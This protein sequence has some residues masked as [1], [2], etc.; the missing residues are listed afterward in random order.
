MLSV[1]RHPPVSQRGVALFV[2]LV[3]VLLSMLL[4]LWA[5]RTALFNEMVVGNDADYQ[6]AYEAAQALLQDAET[7]IQRT[8]GVYDASTNPATLCGGAN[9]CRMN[10]LS[11][12]QLPLSGDP[13]GLTVLLNNLQAQSTY[14]D[15]QCRTAVCAK[16]I[17][18]QDFWNNNTSPPSAE[19]PSFSDMTKV[20]A[21]Y[22]QYTGAVNTGNPILSNTADK[23]GGWY[24]IEVMPYYE[25]AASGNRLIVNPAS[26]GNQLA[27]T[28]NPQVIYRITAVALGIKTGT[29]VVLQETYVQQTVQD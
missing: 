25:G 27:L 16:N 22:G 19:G 2:V 28:L 26:A 13:E 15:V 12:A 23:Q 17:Y 9:I 1:R 10:D 3:F 7:D 20:G 5:S 18:A 8:N 14:H 24:W 11:N 4:A 29:M 6:R 21:R